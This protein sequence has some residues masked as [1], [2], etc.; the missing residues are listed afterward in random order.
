MAHSFHGKS[1][2]LCGQGFIHVVLVDDGWNLEGYE[3]RQGPATFQLCDLLFDRHPTPQIAYTNRNRCIRIL[4]NGLGI[5]LRPCNCPELTTRHTTHNTA[6]F[7]D[8][9]SW[10][11]QKLDRRQV[12]H[13]HVFRPANVD[14]YLAGSLDGVAVNSPVTPKGW[15]STLPEILPESSSVAVYVRVNGLPLYSDSYV[16]VSLLPSRLP[17]I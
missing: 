2:L 9:S 15:T 7:T 6:L 14:L 1:L 16:H 4:V 13:S 8:F 11:S 5:F 3:G 10:P 17:V 12:H